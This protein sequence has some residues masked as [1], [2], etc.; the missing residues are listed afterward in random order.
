M[1]SGGQA[2]IGGDSIRNIQYLLLTHHR[3]IA[4][5]TWHY[6]QILVCD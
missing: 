4:I 6:P 3:V 5:I 1:C 2:P